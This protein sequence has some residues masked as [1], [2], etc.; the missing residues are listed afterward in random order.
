MQRIGIVLGP[1]L[2]TNPGVLSLLIDER[3]RVFDQENPGVLSSICTQDRYAASEAHYNLEDERPLRYPGWVS[4]VVQPLEE[5]IDETVDPHDYY[6]DLEEIAEGESGSFFVAKMAQDKPLENLKLAPLI[7]A[8]DTRNRVN[9]VQTLVAIR[10]VPLVPSGSPEI[11]EVHH[12]LTLLKGLMH[13]NLL[14]MD[15]LYV[16][17]SDDS[18]WIRMELVEWSLADIIQF[19]G[20]HFMLQES[21]MSQFAFDVLSALKYLQSHDIVH[22][23]VRADNLLLNRAGVLKLTDFKNAIKVYRIAP[24]RNEIVGNVDRQPPEMR[25]GVYDAL[26]VDTWSVGATV[27]LMARAKPPFPS[28]E[29]MSNR[30]IEIEQ[31]SES[32]GIFLNMCSQ[33]ESSRPDPQTL[34]ELSSF[35]KDIEHCRTDI[36]QILS[37]CTDIEE[38]MSRPPSESSRPPLTPSDSTYVMPESMD[39][40]QDIQVCG[41]K[42]A[43]ILRV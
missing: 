32:L 10:V 2:G 14:T 25:R 23:D 17:L 21:V 18:L 30:W 16:D 5:F 7:K 40:F 38:K 20:E 36:L 41:C 19:N 31:Y 1:I 28:L 11:N 43:F 27:W 9:G 8:Q 12:E 35:V 26:K 3:N 13:V 39:K 37:Q 42:S 4:N 29:E 6:L 15:A 33:P 34:L 22:R 24:F